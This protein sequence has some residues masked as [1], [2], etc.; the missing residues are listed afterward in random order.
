MCRTTRQGG[1]RAR[2]AVRLASPLN[3]RMP[4]SDQLISQGVTH[5]FR[6]AVNSQL[7]KDALDVIPDRGRADGEV[8]RRASRPAAVGHESEDLEL[9][10]CQI[11]TLVQR[12]LAD[13]P[14]A[15]MTQ[16]GHQVFHDEGSQD[17]NDGPVSEAVPDAHRA[18][19]HPDPL[20]VFL[21]KRDVEVGNGPI[22]ARKPADPATGTA[23]GGPRRIDPPSRR[24]QAVPSTSREEYPSRASHAPFQ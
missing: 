12:G 13:S 2:R 17:V 5:R 3:T 10:P 1:L 18:G 16:T 4:R 11:L 23:H 6:P 19:V 7:G 22:L 21:Q 14:L 24:Q 20:S 8:F 15:E 9:P